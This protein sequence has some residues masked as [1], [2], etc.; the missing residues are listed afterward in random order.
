MIQ[1][2]SIPIF[3][4]NEGENL[5][6]LLPKIWETMQHTSL[7]WE[8]IL[9]DDGSK[10][11]TENIAK[12]YAQHSNFR[13]IKHPTNYGIGRTLKDG[14]EAAQYSNVCAVPGD[15]QFDMNELIPYLKNGIP[16]KGF[17]SFYR[18]ENTQYS[19]FRNILSL[20]NKKV[21]QLLFGFSLRDVNWIK[22]YPNEQVKKF[23]L[24][25]NSSLVE[26]EICIKLV[27]SGYKPI[28]VTSKYL[29]RLAG[30]SKGA[31]FKIVR[32]AILDLIT[33]FNVIQR[34]KA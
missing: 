5:P 21:N 18:I 33:L 16:V 27:K 8:V 22:I 25:I 19:L 4:Y 9:V 32:Q 26:S 14:Y 24:E 6:K 7:P 12:E 34:F 29:P 31:S 23:N 1:G 11:N 20:F 2:W 15:G 17:V 30:V 3:S 10:D 28:E 13:Y